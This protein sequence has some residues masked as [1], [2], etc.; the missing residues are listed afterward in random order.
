M[1]YLGSGFTKS[2]DEYPVVF[3]LLLKRCLQK[4]ASLVFGNLEPFSITEFI[5][6]QLKRAEHC[7][8]IQSQQCLR[9]T[10]ET[11]DL[12]LPGLLHV[13]SYIIR[14]KSLIVSSLKETRRKDRY[15]SLVV[16]LF[17]QFFSK[18]FRCLF[19]FWC[20]EKWVWWVLLHQSAGWSEVLEGCWCLHWSQVLFCIVVF[21]CRFS[22]EILGSSVLCSQFFPHFEIVVGISSSKRVSFLVVPCIHSGINVLPSDNHNFIPQQSPVC[23]YRYRAY[24]DL[25]HIVYCLLQKSKKNVLL[26]VVEKWKCY[27]LWNRS[28]FDP[29]E[30][31]H[32]LK[33]SHVHAALEKLTS[34]DPKKE[35]RTSASRFPEEH[36]WT[37][38]ST[39]PAR[40][41]LSQ[42]VSC[43]CP[44]KMIEG[45][46]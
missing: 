4:T 7:D 46:D 18:K 33:R 42:G 11:G 28:A 24:G 2:F 40:S 23:K 30:E 44:E 29:I 12:S 20:L 17:R 9:M 10:I 15:Q 21:T 32:F 16:W 31:E 38:L 22:V 1:G 25:S 19:S 37:I 36:T 43:F 26:A 35:F 41:K 8:W 13:V 6:S 39:V 34:Y 27:F 3:A 5:V 45:D 14:D